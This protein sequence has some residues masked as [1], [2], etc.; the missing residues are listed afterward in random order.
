MNKKPFIL[1]LAASLVFSA[2]INQAVH[3]E[4]KTW[5]SSDGNW[6]NDSNWFPFGIPGLADDVIVNPYGGVDTVLRFDSFT[7]AQSA[8]SLSINSDTSNTVSFEQTGGSLVILNLEKIGFGFKGNGSYTLSDGANTA[9]SLILGSGWES[10]GSFTQ[11]GGLN[12]INGGLVLGE[13]PGSTGKYV[14]N[15]GSLWVGNE[16]IGIPGDRYMAGGSG[17]FTQNG[18]THTVST[19]LVIS[20]TYNLNDGDLS[21]NSERIGDGR[22]V[23]SGDF[24]QSGGTHTITTDLFIGFGGYWGGHSSYTLAAGS[25]SAGSEFIGDGYSGSSGFFSQ[26]GGTNSVS[27][28]LAIAIFS[29]PVTTTNNGRYY[30]SGGSLTSNSEEIGYNGI[31]NQ[32]GGTHT[33]SNSIIN[34]GAYNVSG[35]VLEVHGGIDNNGTIALTGGATTVNGNVT[36]SVSGKIEVAQSPVIFTGDVVNNGQFKSTHTTVT[37]TGT[38]TENGAYI[39]DPSINNFTNLIIGSSGH[40]IGGTGDEWHITSSFE[41]HSQQNTLWDTL[42]AG[43]FFDGSGMKYLY[44]AGADY[45]QSPLG[46]INNF[47]F[48]SLNLASGVELNIL[49]GNATLGAALYV[50]LIDLGGGL[51]QLNDIHSD[52]NIYYNP[53]LAGNAFL[54]GSTY[55]LDGG[56]LLAPAIPEPQFYVMLLAGLGLLCFAMRRRFEISPKTIRVVRHFQI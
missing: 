45:G 7:G 15:S 5:K 28:T 6:S 25:L 53:T 18:G 19:E 31:F 34:N 1:I 52:Y 27:G 10:N 3:A 22:D 8:N 56:G 55:T 47:A 37:F 33:I 41:N 11:N 50:Q 40:L 14:L 4:T 44:M 38:Y 36:N 23:A 12:R 2:L 39:S 46:F 29:I 17:I 43:L 30:L 35:G 21:T 24:V 26:S 13:G 20:G 32:T 48:E 42:N 9:G 49:D 54:R 51:N 16:S